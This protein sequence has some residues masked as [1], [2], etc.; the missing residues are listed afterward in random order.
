MN[1]DPSIDML[2]TMERENEHMRA[3]LDKAYSLLSNMPSNL[4][5]DFSM[6][7]L[8]IAERDKWLN[9]QIQ[10]AK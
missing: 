2:L 3:Q 9:E 8:W 1:I 7:H 5:S 4:D 10:E 6:V